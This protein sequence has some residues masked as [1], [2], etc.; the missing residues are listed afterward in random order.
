MFEK[1]TTKYTYRVIRRYCLLAVAYLLLIFLLPTNGTSM[2]DYH[3]S[4]LEY[5]VL[6]FAVAIPSLVVWLVAFFGYAKLYEYAASI[7]KTP[8]SKAF[9]SL[10]TGCA[11]LAWSLPIPA[12]VGLITSSMASVWPDFFPSATIIINYSYLVFPLVGFSFIGK[13][14]RELLSQAKIQVSAT[15]ARGIMLFF[16]VGGALYCY[17][18]FRRFDP[19]GLGTTDNPYFLP[20]WLTLITVIIP[21]LYAWFIGLLASYEISTYSKQVRGVLYRQALHL[22]VSGLVVVIIGSIALQYISS[23]QPP[24]GHLA[25][26]YRLLFIIGF[27]IVTGIGFALIAVGAGRLKKIEEV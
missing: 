26:N 14:S 4:A 25:L 15:N 8:E 9:T 6:L 21:Y 18:T 2:Q 12:I 10:A 11:W 23:I 7:Q 5:R 3:L 22:L 27:R 16:V 20:I 13:A 1:S 24:A 19:G 17:L